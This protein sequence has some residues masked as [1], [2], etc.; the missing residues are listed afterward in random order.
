MFGPQKQML[1][2][3]SIRFLTHVHPHN[4]MSAPSYSYKN[5]L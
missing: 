5:D 2:V 1:A 4:I 3:R